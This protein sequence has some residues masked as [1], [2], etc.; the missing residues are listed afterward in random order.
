M[1]PTQI[2]GPKMNTVTIQRFYDALQTYLFHKDNCIITV[3]KLLTQL[4]ITLRI[5]KHKDNQVKLLITTNTKS[6][7]NVRNATMLDQ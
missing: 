4:F 2:M 7:H 1:V 6:S 5:L 3:F